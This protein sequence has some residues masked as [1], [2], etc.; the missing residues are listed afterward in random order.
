MTRY[1]MIA[2]AQDMFDALMAALDYVDDRYAAGYDEPEW[3][4]QARAAIAKACGDD[5]SC[6]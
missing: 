1:P 5:E 4:E 2:A 6:N 3:T